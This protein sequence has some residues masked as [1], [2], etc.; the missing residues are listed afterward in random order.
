MHSFSVNPIINI[1]RTR[2]K[3]PFTHK[4]TFNAGTLVPIRVAEVLPGDTFDSSLKALVRMST[5]IKPVM[6]N[7]FCDIFHFFVPNRLCWSDFQKFMGESDEPFAQT[8]EYSVP[9]ITAPSGGW[10]KGTVADHFG[11]P[12]KIENL[13]I[14]HLPFR[15][16]GLIWNAYFRDQ[17]VMSNTFVN[18]DDATTAGSNGDDYIEDAVKGGALLPVCK[19]HDYFTS[20]LPEPQKGPDVLLPLG[21]SA[22]V[23]TG[24]I[25]NLVKNTN[26][27]LF[28]VADGNDSELP[29]GA[30]F[31]GLNSG[32]LYIQQSNSG[33]NV[34]PIYPVNLYAD[35]T[36]ATAAS[37]NAVRQAFQ[38]QK[39]LEKDA[40]GGTRYIEILKNHFGVT[41]SDAR[42][43]RPEYLGGQ[44]VPITMVQVLQTSS[45][46]TESPQGNTAAFSLTVSNAEGFTKSFEEHGYILT[47]ACVRTKHT[48]QQGINRMWSR[49]SRTDFYMPVF[50][51]LGEQPV[52][53]KEIYAQGTAEDEQGFGYQE[54][55]AEYR[56][57]PDI[58]SG[59]FRANVAE[60][61]GLTI[62]HYADN[63]SELPKLSAD[64]MKETLVNIDRT[65]AI[66]SSVADQ[67]IADF[68]FND[69]VVRPMPAYSIPG[70]ID[71]H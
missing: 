46:D 49:K 26:N 29:V 15:A 52:L 28:R 60:N 38:L 59:E 1:E 64:F 13:S 30:N 23:T 62:W 51:N 41:A 22:P 2:F 21:D 19:Y 31:V 27:L 71:H 12:T 33:N 17:N 68:Y 53:N 35:L 56:Y 48:Y 10:A 50:A 42:L 55:W 36:N 34:N 54:A 45:T 16:Y 39:M 43:Q 63:F 66:Q 61:A 7:C 37:V 24:G 65:L 44:R 6:D 4:T 8:V 20:C 70:L 58:V 69:V 9:Q 18:L 25:L 11:I 40:R 57:M 67:F 3:M 14:N 32:G 47:L 5:P